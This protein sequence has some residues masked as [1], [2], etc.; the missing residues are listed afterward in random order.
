[1]QKKFKLFKQ[2]DN[3]MVFTGTE[4]V[5]NINPAGENPELELLRKEAQDLSKKKQITYEW[6]ESPTL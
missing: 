4:K 2:K 3:R 6:V 1:M 5:I